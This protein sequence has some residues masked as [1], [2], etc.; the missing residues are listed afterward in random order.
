MKNLLR[1]ILVT[2]MFLFSVVGCDYFETHPYDTNIKGEKGLT[3]KNVELIEAMLSDAE[4]FRFAV[5]S[6][7]QGLYDETEQAVK[8][9]NRIEDLDFVIHCGDLTDFGLKKEFQLQRNILQNLDMPWVTVI[10]NHDCL[11]TGQSVYEVIYGKVNYAFTAGNTRFIC[12]NTNAME[13]DYSTPIPDFDFLFSELD[14]LSQNIERV[15]YVMH[16]GPQAIEFNSNVTTIFEYIILD[17]SPSLPFCL[18]GHGHNLSVDDLFGDGI[19]YYQ[20]PNIEKR[21]IL[22][23][24][25]RHDGYDYE[26]ITF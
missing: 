5:I 23:F 17:K 2:I 13:F 9:I 3:Q 4:E 24:T 25:I 18:Y 20:A 19:L 15:V 22:L 6:D 8:A 16:V 7:T 11:G 14:N 1:R 21:T 26:T 12:L 10:G